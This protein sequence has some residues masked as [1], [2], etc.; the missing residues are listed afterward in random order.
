MLPVRSI[1]LQRLVVVC[2]A[3]GALGAPGVVH[4]HGG[5]LSPDAL[6]SAWRWDLVPLVIVLAVAYLRGVRAMRQ[7]ARDRAVY[8]WR[9]RAFSGGLLALGIALVSPL[10]AL[11]SS[12]LS[13]HMAQHLALVLLAA[14]ALALA[15][16]AG[17]LLWA[18]PRSF[19]LGLTP[20][21]SRSAVVG[22]TGRALRSPLA[23]GALHA[24]LLWIWHLPRLYE[25]ALQS[26]LTHYLEHI[27]LLGSALLFWQAIVLAGLA[28]RARAGVGILACFVVSLTGALLG[29]LMAFS[30]TLWY[31]IYDHHASAW[32]VSALADQQAAG[33]LMWGAGGIVYAAAALTLFG[34]WLT[35]T[36]AGDRAGRSAMPQHRPPPARQSSRAADGTA[37]GASARGDDARA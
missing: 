35:G 18:L 32:S 27:T 7:R 3:L 29:A 25:G 19:R 37:Q 26:E 23:A 12:L 5:G 34:R 30:R 8:R 17:P 28:R 13:A 4:A 6:W 2:A 22:F 11:G 14:P 20:W 21:W 1:G 10:D 9:T 15:A 24:G 16:P 33:L 31:P 36:D